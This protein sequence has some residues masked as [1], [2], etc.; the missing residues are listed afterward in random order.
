[1]IPEDVVETGGLRFSGGAGSHGFFIE[2]E[3]IVGWDDSPGVR[4]DSVE[5]AHADGDFD[6]NEVLYNARLLTVSGLC[7]AGSSE[8]LGVFRNRLMGLP[9]TGLRTTA[10]TFGTTTFAD[11]GTIAAASKFEVVVPG[12]I[13]RYQFSR[14]FTNPRRY[15]RLN[16][17]SSAAD[18]SLT[19]QHYG[20]ARASTRFV[21]AATPGSAGSRW[22]ITG[23]GGRSIAVA[24]PLQPGHPHEYDM[25]TGQ[26]RI[27][28]VVQYGAV[29][30]ADTWS[31]PPGRILQ[32]TLS[33]QGTGATVDAFTYD[34]YV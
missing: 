26:L 6:L 19:T 10:T 2:E 17:S 13:A 5:R 33:A 9:T 3:G 8:E 29:E 4:F 32:H 28:G 25:F 20:N 27:D 23:P 7:H 15:G 31:I 1:M 24:A 30:T 14:R 21:V 22:R 34:T 11:G 16:K 12:K 18:G